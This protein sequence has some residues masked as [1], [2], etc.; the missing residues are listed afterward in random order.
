MQIEKNCVSMLSWG[1]LRDEKI[2]KRSLAI[3]QFALSL[4]N[5]YLIVVQLLGK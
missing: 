4:I 2:N 1:M 5:I 3:S